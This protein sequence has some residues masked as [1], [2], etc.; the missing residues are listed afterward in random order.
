MDTAKRVSPRLPAVARAPFAWVPARVQSGGVAR[1]LNVVFAAALDEGE[2]DFLS[3]RAVEVVVSDAAIR[4][5][6]SIAAGRFVV[7]DTPADLKLEGTAYTFLL[8]ASRNE[9]ADTLFFNRLLKTSGD[10][11]LGL[12]IKNF[13]AGIDPESLPGHQI[14]DPVLGKLLAVAERFGSRGN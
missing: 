1:V 5:T 6:L 4:F 11:E 14:V 12:Y 2:L 10:T 13:L 7:A 8:L 3:G 9:D